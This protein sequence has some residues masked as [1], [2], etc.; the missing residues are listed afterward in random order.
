MHKGFNGS[1]GP[2]GLWLATLLASLPLAGVAEASEHTAQQSAAA[3]LLGLMSQGY[4]QVL[5]EDSA[6][7]G[8]EAMARYQVVLQAE[9]QY[10]IFSTGDEGVADLDILVV[11]EN[12]NEVARDEQVD[13][14]P[15]VILTPRWTGSFVIYIKNV[16]LTPGWSYTAIAF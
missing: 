16:G 3:M 10:A 8:P 1:R 2:R 5:K 9:E 12:G 15:V 13:P 14:N 4:S 7:L 6:R 11:D